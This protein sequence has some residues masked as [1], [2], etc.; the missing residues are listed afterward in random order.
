MYESYFHFDQ[1]PFENTPDPTFFYGSEQH[2]E[3]LAA[4]V[5]GIR[6]FKGFMLVT[7]DVGTGKTLLAQS[8]KHEMDNSEDITKTVI[9]QISNPWISHSEL[10][11]ELAY[12]LGIKD[13]E[14]SNI[15]AQ[16][17]IQ[18]ELLKVYES[19]GRVILIL[20]EAQQ[21]PEKTLEGVR[22]L[23][24]ME[25][26]HAKLIQII[27]LGQT[28]FNDILTRHSM[29]QLRQ[30]VT[31][32]RRLEPLGLDDTIGYIDHRIHVAG[33]ETTPFTRSAIHAIY[34]A[35]GGSPRLINQICD[36]A[37]IT[38]YASKQQKIDKLIIAEVIADLPIVISSKAEQ[39]Q[40]Q[41]AAAEEPAPQAPQ[42]PETLL[43]R[44][45]S[46]RGLSDNAG[47][48]TDKE[49]T[50]KK[51][52]SNTGEVPDLN[53]LAQQAL[54]NAMNDSLTSQVSAVKNSHGR[55]LVKHTPQWLIY[56]L[57]SLTSVLIGLGATSLYLD[58][59]Q[60]SAPE[61]AMD[62]QPQPA[63]APIETAQPEEPQINVREEQAPSQPMTEMT[64]TDNG[65][66]RVY[67]DPIERFKDL[68]SPRAFKEVFD[69]QEPTSTSD[70][71]VEEI[72]KRWG[73]ETD[74]TGSRNQPMAD[75]PSQIDPYQRQAQSSETRPM[76][77][78]AQTA[79]TRS[80]ILTSPVETLMKMNQPFLLLPYGSTVSQIARSKYTTWNDTVRD[81][82][83]LANPSLNGNIDSGKANQRIYLPNLYKDDLLTRGNDGLWYIYAGSY[84]ARSRAEKVVK[85]LSSIGLNSLAMEQRRY[86]E[87]LHRAFIGPFSSIREASMATDNLRLDAMPFVR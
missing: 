8:L 84:E 39:L 56:L 49:P 57:V 67:Q 78:M 19:K 65:Y 75:L 52:N 33:A 72:R 63:S 6:Q 50:A 26:P 70:T 74:T 20:D 87:T 58:S 29:R 4:L 1:L 9:I 37:L 36:N 31:L 47:S 64:D 5:Y 42:K 44:L 76:Q 3:A 7:G 25:V 28:E 83:I 35:S 11:Q 32:S 24:N 17:V 71:K 79:N 60:K 22:L 80:V 12:R 59:K 73:F 41:A 13:Q 43:Q 53:Y 14:S 10:F 86:N 18:E 69:E 54:L 68:D 38:A 21:I 82:V 62:S 77:N 81:I 51:H 40:S 55:S 85:N 2:R 46:E 45:A 48:D 16:K 27:L 30:R 23:S 34:E 15:E 61:K 66:K